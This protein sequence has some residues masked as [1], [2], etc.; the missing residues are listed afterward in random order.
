MLQNKIFI[1]GQ[2]QSRRRDVGRYPS[3]P[4]EKIAPS[5]S[6]PFVQTHR[7][8]FPK[9]KKRTIRTRFFRRRTSNG[10]RATRHDVEG[11]ERNRY[12]VDSAGRSREKRSYKRTKTTGPSPHTYSRLTLY[13]NLRRPSSSFAATESVEF[14]TRPR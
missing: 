3:W 2:R 4:A 5:G 13:P 7:A 1:C 10:A 9:E 6:V 12:F 14:P 8:R 11:R